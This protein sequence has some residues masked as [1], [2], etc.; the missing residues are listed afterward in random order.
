[1]FSAIAAF[2]A[3]LPEIISLIRSLLT[4]I[5]D[6]ED[7]AA[8]KALAQKFAA[9]TKIAVQTGDTSELENIFKTGNQ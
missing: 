9:A 7:R 1:M 3:A 4:F 6:E 2:L 8:K 5:K